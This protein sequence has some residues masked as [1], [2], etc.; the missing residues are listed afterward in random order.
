MP[1]FTS[2]V[3][4]SRCAATGKQRYLTYFEARDAAVEI[5]RTTGENHGR[6]YRCD[7]CGDFHLGK[8]GP[9]R[10]APIQE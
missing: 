9:D 1:R 10:N 8:S 3:A 4:R 5:E 2:R 6:P 7:K